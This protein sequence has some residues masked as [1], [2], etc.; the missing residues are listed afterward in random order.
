MWPWLS[1]K[2]LHVLAGVFWVGAAVFVAGWLLPAARA[3]GP[4]GGPVLRQIGV[5]R[6]LPVA[7]NIAA[8]LT[9]ISGLLLYWRASAG[10]QAS[11]TAT[12]YGI[13][14][15]VGAVSG[16]LAFVWGVFVQGPN[17]QRLAAL[18]AKAASVAGSPVS[19]IRTIARPPASARMSPRLTGPDA[20][21]PQSW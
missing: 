16:V 12:P 20:W 5:A 11:P 15:L 14:L 7:F 9:L 8:I 6:R 19:S 10:L 18:A 1:L 4:A 17:G 21:I 13:A 2:L 3:V